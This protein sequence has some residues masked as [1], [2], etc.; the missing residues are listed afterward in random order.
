MPQIL[1][2]HA[3][4][5]LIMHNNTVMSQVHTLLCNVYISAMSWLLYMCTKVRW[6]TVNT[7]IF[8][9]YFIPVTST[10]YTK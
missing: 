5:Q 7:G 4:M 3:V 8:L 1:Q 9:V 2:L 6:T 10:I